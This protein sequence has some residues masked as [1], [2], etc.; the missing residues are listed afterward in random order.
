MTGSN[1]DPEFPQDREGELQQRAH[2]ALNQPA[3]AALIALRDLIK[4][5]AQTEGLRSSD[6]ETLYDL[7]LTAAAAWPTNNESCDPRLTTILTNLDRLARS[8][9]R[10]DL[11]DAGITQENN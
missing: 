4:H 5:D 11:A 10:A 9:I 6:D 2:T 3:P 8:V 1:P 7:V